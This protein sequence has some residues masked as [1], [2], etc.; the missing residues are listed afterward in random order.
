VIVVLVVMIA[1]RGGGSSGSAGK[2]SID[3]APEIAIAPIDVAPAP[4]IDAGV[5]PTTVADAALAVAGD[6]AGSPSVPVDATAVRV[7]PGGGKPKP[8]KLPRPPKPPKPPPPEK[9]VAFD[10]SASGVAQLYGAVGRELKALD[11]RKGSTATS[12]LWP[13]YLR[14]RINDAL[15]TPEKRAEAHRALSTLR[16]EIAAQR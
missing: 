12:A 4:A 16:T 8:P 2:T 6:A 11:V 10:T 3:A 9:P 5:A 1:T 13:R 15:A 14:I 7:D